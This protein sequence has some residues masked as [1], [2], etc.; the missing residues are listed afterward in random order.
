MYLDVVDSTEN[1]YYVCSSDEFEYYSKLDLKILKL[2]NTRSLTFNKIYL[3]SILETRL[4]H[5]TQFLKLKSNERIF[6]IHCMIWYVLKLNAMYSYIRTMYVLEK[7]STQK[8]DI[9]RLN[10]KSITTKQYTV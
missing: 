4:K 1:L 9:L 7:T 8:C 10:P 3:L 6:Q 2:E 5:K